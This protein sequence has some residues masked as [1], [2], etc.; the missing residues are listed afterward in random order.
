MLFAKGLRASRSGEAPRERFDVVA[1]AAGLI[2]TLQHWFREGLF[3]RIFKNAGLLLGGRAA[4][5]IISLG[6]LS[7]S[8]RGLGLEQFGI[9][10]LVQTY[11]QVITSL[12]TFQS[13]QA[14]IRYGAIA[15]ER[16]DR[17]ALQSLLKFMALL[18]IGGGVL[19]V[20]VA[21]LFASIV[22][23]HVGWNEDI[24]RY[25]Q[26]YSCLILFTACA[27][28]TG[29]LRLLDR[30]DLLAIQTTI[31]PFIRLI[32]IITAV[33]LNAPLWA[34]LLA[35]FSAQLVGGLTLTYLGWREIW[36]RGHFAGMTA[37]LKDLTQAHDGLLKFAVCSNIYMGLNVI[38]NQKSA[39][40][41]GLL[42][43]PTAA[44]IFKIG[45]DAATILSKPAELLNQS[46]YPEFARLGS[47]GS[48]DEF[49]RIILRSAAVA[50]GAALVVIGVV[51][52]IGRPFLHLVFGEEFTT[53]YLPLVLMVG[54]A[55]VA[56]VGFP[57]DAALFAM[58]RASLPLRVSTIITAA[59]HLPLMV[60]LVRLNGAPGAG[61]A[62]LAAAAAMVTAMTI[63]TASH[64]R[65][66]A[67]LA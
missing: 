41:V 23:P 66:R 33:V 46:I 37:S 17:P 29:I 10:V 55:G 26:L 60:V 36:R 65:Q 35:W 52:G 19:G 58:G 31:T 28:P 50:S 14:V 56:I 63:V 54:A 43:G 40:L 6:V 13:C 44:G 59:I 2:P 32:G 22:G 42:A 21:F 30:F 15:L 7:L 18:D 8:A 24:I 5:G 34:Y 1:F 4:T 38:V 62:N 25:A 61:F 16:G 49:G 57:L 48:W 45:R 39:L 64:M 27:T 47:A 9:L 3:R 12:I 20:L 67:A 51:I 11:A 53:A